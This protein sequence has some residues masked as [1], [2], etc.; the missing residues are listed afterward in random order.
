MRNLVLI[1]VGFLVMPAFSFASRCEKLEE[2]AKLLDV[3]HFRATSL[4]RVAKHLPE[5]S[6]VMNSVEQARNYVQNFPA[7]KSYGFDV[8]N[9]THWTRYY[10]KME[11]SSLYGKFVGWQQKLADGK[12]A[13]FR[14][15]FEP[16]VIDPVTK[17]ITKKGRGAHYNIEMQVPG[18]QGKKETLKLSV[19]ILCAGHPCS[20]AETLKLVNR[21]GTGG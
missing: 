17:Q 19:E 3:S 4:E 7:F 8:G 11:K 20:E 10:A 6:V 18:N 9:Y 15:D 16:D 14:M 13:R 21:M 5:Q 2:A 12:F 1:A